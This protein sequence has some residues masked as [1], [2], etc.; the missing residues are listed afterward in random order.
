[1]KYFLQ[2]RLLFAIILVG[3]ACDSSLLNTE[4]QLAISDQGVLVD[5][6][7][8]EA[9]LVGAYDV[10]QGYASGVIVNLD[11]ASDNVVNFNNQNDIIPLQRPGGGGSFNAIYRLINQTNFLIK[12]LPALPE[13]TF[14]P[15]AKNR[16]LGEAYFLRALGYFDL[17]RLYGGVQIVLEP[18]VSP[19]SHKGTQRSSL[20]ETYAQVLIDLN[21][22]EELLPAGL[23]RS[24]ASKYAVYALKSRLYLYL[25]NWEQAEN[26]AT[27]IIE[28]PSF[29]LVEPFS[30]FF[31]GRNTQESIFELIYSTMDRTGF[32]QNW[33]SPSDG[34]RHDY[35]PERSFVSKILN[36]DLGGT[37]KS[38]LKQTAEGS[39]D[40][41]LYGKQ[42]G[43]SS[44]FLFRL[45][46]QYLNR[47]EARLRKQNTDIAG[48]LQDLN[49]IKERAEVP[50]LDPAASVYTPVELLDE[51]LEER[52]F[53]L[54]FEG[55]RFRDVI[56]FGKA[57]EIFGAI[58]P[59]LANPQNWVFPIPNTA[60][61]NDPDLTQNPGY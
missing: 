39:W 13:Q 26:Y 8:A 50:Q 10:L 7:S 29:N 59:I 55:F 51:V 12:N 11:L 34:G 9:T 54:G 1:M 15:G 17:G 18:T 46:E 32:W 28:D 49:K 23:V 48:S 60:L 22:A 2:F 25:E 58:N 38:Q 14:Q 6:K 27:K 36:P 41:I 3:S 43:T 19:D 20:Q 4:P 47:A 5:Q 30:T 37:R 61:D 52:R 44:I 42:D 53:E 24:R 21:R 35:V 57:A 33:L 45:A 40:L 16:I 31:Q 56:R